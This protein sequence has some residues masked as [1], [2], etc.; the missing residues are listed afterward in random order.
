[1]RG[2][3]S[4]LECRERFATIERSVSSVN[5]NSGF[6]REQ[7]PDGTMF[8]WGP[9]QYQGN[10]LQLRAAVLIHEIGH[11]LNIAGFQHDNGIPKAGKAN[12]KMVYQNCKG[13]IEGIH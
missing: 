10:T 7:A 11:G 6:F 2:M 9:P 8:A 5:D 3:F 4:R 1:M 12:D 13:L